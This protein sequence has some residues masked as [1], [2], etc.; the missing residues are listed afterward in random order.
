MRKK[1]E[2]HKRN[3]RDAR[4]K[5]CGVVAVVT[6]PSFPVILYFLSFSGTK[7]QQQCTLCQVVAYIF[8]K[9]LIIKPSRCTDFYNL[10]L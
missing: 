7:L 1:V 4:E 3:S 10:F 5:R 8:Q 2:E 9:I 6:F